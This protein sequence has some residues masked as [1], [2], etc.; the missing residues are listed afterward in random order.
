MST[1]EA[2]T[3]GATPGPPAWFW[4][5]GAEAE[6]V[7]YAVLSYFGVDAS[8]YSFA[9]VAR[10]AESKEVVKAALSNIQRTVRTIIEAAEGDAPQEAEGTL[11]REAA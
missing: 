10:W 11:S 2:C 7:T 1:A 4:S 8:G 3:S 9:Y 6:G 5:T